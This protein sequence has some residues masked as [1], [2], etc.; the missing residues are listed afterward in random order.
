MEFT[1]TLIKTLASSE[2]IN[3]SMA[4][5]FFISVLASIFCLDLLSESWIWPLRFVFM[6]SGL[7]V[8]LTSILEYR[9]SIYA[10]IEEKKIAQAKKNTISRLDTKEKAIMHKFKEMKSNIIK[11]NPYDPSVRRLV[12]LGMINDLAGYKK[13][14][15][16]EWEAS[17][18]LSDEWMPYVLD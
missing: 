14:S 11:L 9:K 17:F 12:K 13:I 5:V 8:V 10:K 3:K 16:S 18:S 6:F 1:S 7:W 4:I 15:N 2:N